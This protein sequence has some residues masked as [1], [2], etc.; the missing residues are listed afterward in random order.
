MFASLISDNFSL[1]EVQ[2]GCR[3][4]C[5]VIS[6]GFRLT[7][8]RSVC[9]QNCLL[10]CKKENCVQHSIEFGIA[11]T[12]R[13]DCNGAFYNPQSKRRVEKRMS[14]RTVD[15]FV[16]KVWIL[17]KTEIQDQIVVSE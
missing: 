15:N 3:S 10:Y 16:K 2:A 11:N 7:L 9:L 5:R 14:F 13:A 4:K 17:L 6:N 12:D 1:P 8:L